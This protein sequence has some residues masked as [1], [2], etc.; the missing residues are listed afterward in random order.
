MSATPPSATERLS[1]QMQAALHLKRR[2][3]AVLGKTVSITRLRKDPEL[4]DAVRIEIAVS[5]DRELQYLFDVAFGENH[6]DVLE[7]GSLFAFSAPAP[8]YADGPD[9][10]PETGARPWWIV[11]AV[12]VTLIALSWAW[13]QYSRRSA[14]P[15]LA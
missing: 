7:S 12:L 5:G 4:L 6:Q 14:A 8:T 10:D 13:V 9:R 15:A 3:E 1:R 11:G 2:Y